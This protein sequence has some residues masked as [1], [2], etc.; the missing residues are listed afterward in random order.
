MSAPHIRMTYEDF[1]KTAAGSHAALLALGRSVDETGLEKELTEL[2]KLRASQINGCAFCLQHHLNIARKLG[3]AGIKLDLVA[4]WR[5]AGVF[6]PREMAALAWTEALT[7]MTEEVLSD[8][9]YAALLRHFTPTEAVFLTIAIGTINQW[10][11]IA[12][13]LRFP[14][15]LPARTPERVA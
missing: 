1:A 3:I 7:G 8:A 11:R 14:P 5:E 4:A 10:N 6:T 15:S 9:A 12:V 13:A 2:V